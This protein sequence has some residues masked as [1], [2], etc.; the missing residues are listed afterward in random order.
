M[1]AVSAGEGGAEGG[2]VAGA[3][4]AGNS[5]GAAGNSEAEARKLPGGL[6]PAVVV[7]GAL[8][9]GLLP[10]SGAGAALQSAS[11]SAAGRIR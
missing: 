11:V 8:A 1:A 4:G 3:G 10:E 5:P 7:P 6:P 2:D 9:T